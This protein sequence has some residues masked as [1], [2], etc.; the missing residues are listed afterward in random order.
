MRTESD[1]NVG[2]SNPRENY[3]GSMTL[4]SKSFRISVHLSGRYPATRN[5][6]YT[7][8]FIVN[9]LRCRLLKCEFLEGDT[10][11]DDFRR[12]SM[13]KS[14]NFEMFMTASEK[15]NCAVEHTLILFTASFDSTRN[16]Y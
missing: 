2:L 12:V 5:Y 14:T 7:F 8:I 10:S 4:A 16:F 15:K 6:G 1:L 9:E 13:R 3:G 11:P